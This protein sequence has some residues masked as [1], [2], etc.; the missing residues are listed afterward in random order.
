MTSTFYWYDLETFGSDPRRTRITQF[1]GLR[2]DE[3]LNPVGE[4]LVLYCKPAD[5][6]LPSPEAT[7]ITGITPQRALR[8]GVSEAELIGHVLD[9]FAVPQTCVTGYNSLR[10]DDEFIRYALYR[11]F[12]DP[13]E[14][15]WRGGNSRWDLLDLFRLAHALR[16]DGM[17]WPLREDGAPSF[18][19]THLSAANGIGHDHAHDALSDVQA[20]I[21]LAKKLKQAQPR[22]FDYY[23]G[24]R[25]K[26]R[27]ASLLDVAQMTPVLH[28]SGK[29]SAA[30]G[31]AALVAPI[32]RHPQ[33][34]SRVVVFDLD[35]DPEALL[36]LDPAA[37][38][39]RL[40][41]PAADLPEGE[42]RIPLKEVHLNRCPALVAFEH[43]RADDFTRLCIDPD[44]ALRRV[45]ALR[46][47]EGLA[48]KVRQVYAR[49]REPRSVDADAALYDAFVPDH[50]K[51]LFQKVRAAAPKALPAFAAQFEDQRLRE[52]VFRYQARNWPESLD[53][54]QQARWDDY[55]RTRLGSDIGLS[56]YSFETYDGAIA[57]LRHVH[58]DDGRVQALLDAL[59]D[60]GNAIAATL[61]PN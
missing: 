40:Y 26:R 31:S 2:T 10:F 15:E 36:A 27:A 33:I 43:L 37:I 52:L 23:L 21:G 25:D 8:E 51:R 57:S 54:A 20:L 13:Y 12:H 1:A 41:T 42:S 48:T 53:A 47:A 14:R 29:Y 45:E 3:D 58:A 4:P 39:D 6:L 55:R 34:E 19:L 17:A 46:A 22:L 28:V 32:C 30:R 50:D 38:A 5:D 49:S 61:P 24:L 56:E 7:L 35:A 11:N 18:K 44:L 59:Q 9:E 16:P 60:W